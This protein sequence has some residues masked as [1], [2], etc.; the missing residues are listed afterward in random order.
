MERGLLGRGV[1][2]AAAGPD[3][4]PDATVVRLLAEERGLAVVDNDD[5]A[6]GLGRSLRLG[7]EALGP[8]PVRAALVVLGD[9]PRTDLDVIAA[10]VGEWRR[11][12]APILVP[13]YRAAG[14]APGNPVVLRRDAWHLARDLRGDRGMSAI[15]G[16]V[17][18]LVVYLDVEGVNPDVDRP[19]DL[20]ALSGPPR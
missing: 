9:Q 15:M 6:A 11:R 5:P 13:R 4:P 12:R 1:V 16:R 20:E 10:L 7:L 18:D 3:A 2:V 17:P 8:L 14:G 19:A